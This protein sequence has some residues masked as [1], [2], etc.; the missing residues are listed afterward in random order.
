MDPPQSSNQA[1]ISSTESLVSK[2]TT[3]SPPDGRSVAGQ[4]KRPTRISRRVYRSLRRI[5]RPLNLASLAVLIFVGMTLHDALRTVIVV[6]P[7]TVP[8]SFEKSGLT[9]NVLSNQL[10]DQ[11][12]RLRPTINPEAPREDLYANISLTMLEAL[13]RV[14]ATLSPALQPP[15]LEIPKTG[16]SLKTLSRYV[17][18]LAGTDRFRISGALVLIGDRHRLSI[19]V[20]NS[21]AEVFHEDSKDTLKAI[22]R[23]MERAAK[24]IY[25]IL[26]PLVWLSWQC[27][28]GRRACESELATN[29]GW[30]ADQLLLGHFV[31]GVI[32][33]VQYRFPEAEEQFQAVLV[34][35][36]HGQFRDPARLSEIRAIACVNAAIALK[37]QRRFDAA[38]KT[39]ERP[40]CREHVDN[41]SHWAETLLELDRLDEAVV[42]AETGAQLAEKQVQRSKQSPYSK[43]SAAYA[44]SILGRALFE[45]HRYDDALVKLRRAEQFNPAYPWTFFWWA[46]VLQAQG[47]RQEAEQMLAN[48]A[49]LAGSDVGQVKYLVATLHAEDNR[50]AEAIEE[51][52]E[53]VRVSPGFAEPY[54]QLCLLYSQTRA[55]R[56]AVAH[57]YAYLGLARAIPNPSNEV[58]AL[59]A[60]A[61][62]AIGMLSHSREV[63]Q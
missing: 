13:Y 48:V 22:D 11:I 44:N 8:E 10:I 52:L 17:A 45:K 60:K 53:L 27:H 39:F 7:L 36:A 56:D 41:F 33:A 35:E 55:N 19:R 20:G 16:L 40:I 15:D 34:S 12:D 9:G 6:D 43:Y 49:K 14:P 5:T 57:C 2:D 62:K 59:M 61:A 38:L 31:A 54:G 21:P 50:V 4:T 47:K 58:G 28:D 23:L 3:A 42:T 24:R 1:E 37:L 51:L 29:Q 46:R 32:R 26:Q 25:R 18:S 63:S 30:P